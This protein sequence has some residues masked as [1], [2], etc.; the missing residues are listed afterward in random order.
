M[1]ETRERKIMSNL[2]DAKT[3]AALI[4]GNAA[5]IKMVEERISLMSKCTDQRLRD[6]FAIA[7][8]TGYCADNHVWREAASKIRNGQR[9]CDVVAVWAYEQADAMMKAREQVE[10]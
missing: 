6:Q 9:P 1:A 7:A 10:R 3:Q 8:M 4:S 2:K 5:M